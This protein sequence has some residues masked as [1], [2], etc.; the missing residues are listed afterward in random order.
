M[1]QYRPTKLS[2][3]CYSLFAINNTRIRF[4]NLGTKCF[5]VVTVVVK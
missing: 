2:L 3:R 5:F 1:L 4:L